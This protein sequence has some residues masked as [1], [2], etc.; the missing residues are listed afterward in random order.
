MRRKE[1]P[2][3]VISADLGGRWEAA[4][5]GPKCMEP[6]RGNGAGFA[7]PSPGEPLGHN[8]EVRS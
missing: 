5:I 3:L 1:P 6:A 8:Q 4:A 7:T 2:G